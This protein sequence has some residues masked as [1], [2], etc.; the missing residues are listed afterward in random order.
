MHQQKFEYPPNRRKLFIGGLSAT[1]TEDQIKTYFSRYADIEKCNIIL[2]KHT[3]RSR[4]FGFLIL[5]KKSSVSRILS[6]KHVLDNK[7][8]DCKPAFPKEKPSKT[9]GS[10]KVFVGGLLP[11]TTNAEFADYFSQYGQIDDSIVMKDRG[12]GKARG[13]GFVTFAKEQSVEEVMKNYHNHFLR[14]KWVECKRAVA[15]EK[16]CSSVPNVSICES[17]E[18]GRVPRKRSGNNDA[19]VEELCRELIGYILD[20]E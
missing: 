20:E 1:T 14:G 17:V 10:R 6:A 4:C 3:G 12:S 8:I 7:K 2:D 16:L 5:S 19:Y 11:E 9:P 18:A 13:F 15:K